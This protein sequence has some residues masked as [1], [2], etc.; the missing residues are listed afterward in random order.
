MCVCVVRTG[1]RAEQSLFA[2]ACATA[3]L[4]DDGALGANRR[5]CDRSDESNST[6]AES[7]MTVA[8]AA[9]LWDITTFGPSTCFHREPVD[10]RTLSAGGASP[11]RS[12]VQGGAIVYVR[13]LCSGRSETPTARN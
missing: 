11:A 2:V 4:A 13:T 9:H 5:G 6:K 8:A 1:R 7:Q 3:R 12:S 10:S